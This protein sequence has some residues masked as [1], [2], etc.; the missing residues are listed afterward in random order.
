MFSG[1][2]YQFDPF[3]AV[4]Q[5]TGVFV[6]ILF[7]GQAFTIMLVYIWARRNPLVRMN[8]FGLFNFQAPYLP[9]VLLGF[10]LLLGNSVTVDVMGT[11]HFFASVSYLFCI[12][13]LL[14]VF[15]RRDRC[16]AHLLLLRRRLSTPTW[17]FQ[18]STYSLDTVS[19][20]MV[21]VENVVVG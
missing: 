11:K 20:G 15:L 6:Q 8:F 1:T 5:I 2:R 13:N 17:R 14:R 3:C 21:A 10:S 4:F 16:W 12:Q 18:D 7:L 19:T 9:W